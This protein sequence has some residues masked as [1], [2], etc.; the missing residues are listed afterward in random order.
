MA[1]PCPKMLS[2]TLSIAG[3]MPFK[4]ETAA[5]RCNV[6]FPHLSRA[7]RYNFVTGS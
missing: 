3:L 4:L 7:A 6:Y 1:A 5:S 2:A